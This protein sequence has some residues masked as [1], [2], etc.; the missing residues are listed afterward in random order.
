MSGIVSCFSNIVSLDCDRNFNVPSEGCI[1][2]YFFLNGGYTNKG[3][4][5]YKKKYFE[6]TLAILFYSYFARSVFHRP[7]VLSPPFSLC[8]TRR[9]GILFGF[10]LHGNVSFSLPREVVQAFAD[11]STRNSRGLAVLALLNSNITYG[12]NAVNS[13][14]SEA[15]G[16][17]RRQWRVDRP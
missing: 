15:I 7:F 4:K 17:H 8:R 11:F 5:K 1:Y 13:V 3:A 14:T 16:V 12:G 10:E 9:S 6:D 2:I